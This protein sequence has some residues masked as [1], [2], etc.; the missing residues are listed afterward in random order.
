MSRSS[1]TVGDNP[2]SYTASPPSDTSS[3]ATSS[4]IQ[5]RRDAILLLLLLLLLLPLSQPDR[6]S[7]QDE[8]RR[9]DDHDKSTN[10]ETNHRTGDALPLPLCI[11]Q[12]SLGLGRNR[13][14]HWAM[15]TSV[16]IVTTA[17]IGIKVLSKTISGSALLNSPIPI[18]LA[19]P[20]VR[21]I[22]DK[23]VPI[24]PG[25]TP[26]GAVLRRRL[27][28]VQD[29]GLALPL[30][31]EGTPP[32]LKPKGVMDRMSELGVKAG[33]WKETRKERRNEERRR[34]LKRL[35]EE[36]LENGGSR[37]NLGSSFV[38]DLGTRGGSSTDLAGRVG[39]RTREICSNSKQRWQE[40][41]AQSR[42]SPMQRKVAEQDLLERWATDKV[43]WIV[44]MNKDNDEQIEIAESLD[45]EERVDEETWRM[46]MIHEGEEL[47]EEREIL[48]EHGD[49]TSSNR[50]GTVK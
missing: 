40:R 39:N 25:E 6:T 15:I 37:L 47:R 19:G 3:D 49:D 9:P 16:I 13:P 42:P 33:N 41:T 1:S 43:L 29:P 44:M 23:P 21:A 5:L 27:T 48:E 34:M 24:P 36:T 14:Y 50:R 12:I 22:A 28:V 4:G 20:I 46:E 10:Q 18:P 7:S 26:E 30:Q 32:P 2:P 45:D 8:Q 38:R 17:E 11:P 31:F 35:D